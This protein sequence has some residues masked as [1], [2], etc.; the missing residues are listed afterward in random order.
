MTAKPTKRLRK[1]RPKLTPTIVPTGD[2]GRFR[3]VQPSGEASEPMTL[4]EAREV[5]RVAELARS[6][7]G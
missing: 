4:S 6:P 3:V 7:V 5:L 1:A 2:L